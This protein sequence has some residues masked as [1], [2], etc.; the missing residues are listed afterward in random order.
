VSATVALESVMET[1]LSE[2]AQ[3]EQA[4]VNIQTLATRAIM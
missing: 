2:C 3:L 4:I 1:W